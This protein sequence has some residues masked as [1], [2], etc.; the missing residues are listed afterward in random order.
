MR[1][2]EA[3]SLIFEALKIP[4]WNQT[5]SIFINVGII[6]ARREGK[7]TTRAIDGRQFLAR[8]DETALLEVL[9]SLIIQGILV[10]GLDDA[11]Q[12]WTFL[13]LTEYGKQCLAEDRVL[14]HDPDGYLKEFDESVPMADSTIREYLTEALQCFIRGLY[15]ASAV[16]LGGASEKA[17]L[18]M[19]ESFPNSLGDPKLGTQFV[20]EV[21][22]A[23]T[24]FRKYA[25]FEDRFN[26]I[27]SKLPR[28]L[29]E[30]VDSLL[31]GVFDL[32]RSTRNDAGHPASGVIV[33][34]DQV[35]AHLRLFIPYCTRIHRLN[36]WF[37]SNKV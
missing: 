2:E 17:V 4:G 22:Q 15:R 36:S 10:P 27:R 5:T 30:N 16:M 1:L 11:N 9:W 29:T 19:I 14:P 13:R 24:I 21:E 33:D 34:R 28:E 18:L 32:I 20:R 37:E 6:K 3:R 8:G 23:P 35:Y 25:I 12:G 7:D 26:K 31:R